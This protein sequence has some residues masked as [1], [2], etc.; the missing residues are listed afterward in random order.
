MKCR[1]E[2]PAARQVMQYSGAHIASGGKH[3]SA[4][5]QDLK[6]ALTQMAPAAV[7]LTT[8][9]AGNSNWGQPSQHTRAWR[10]S[11]PHR[12]QARTGKPD[13]AAT[14]SQAKS[15]EENG[16]QKRTRILLYFVC[17][18]SNI[19]DVVFA[20]ARRKARIS[21]WSRGSSPIQGLETLEN[22]CFPP[23]PYREQKQKLGSSKG[24]KGPQK[25][26][27]GSFHLASADLW[28][29]SP[30]RGLGRLR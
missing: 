14:S 25:F 4:S 19:D 16:A 17:Y 21:M 28:R 5:A 6:P 20:K 22:G 23:F 13:F 1:A 24:P 15:L 3:E 7:T 9:H 12:G 18:N 8:R 10:F 30:A 11:S 29:S 26:V 27:H 2:Q